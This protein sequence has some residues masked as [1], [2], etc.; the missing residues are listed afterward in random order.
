MLS[1]ED[2]ILDIITI[3]STNNLS[4]EFKFKCE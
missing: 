1:G 3:D 2:S 4:N